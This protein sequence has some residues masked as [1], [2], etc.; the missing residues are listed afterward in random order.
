MNSDPLLTASVSPSPTLSP[1][2]LGLGTSIS[3]YYRL[4]EA[5]KPVVALVGAPLLHAALFEQI[6]LT[7]ANS[8]SPASSSSYPSASFTTLSTSNNSDAA[9]SSLNLRYLS[10]RQGQNLPKKKSN[11]RR[12]MNTALNNASPSPLPTPS[13]SS[14]YS[15]PSIPLSSSPPALVNPLVSQP[16]YL[17]SPQSFPSPSLTTAPTINPSSPVPSALS[18][19]TLATPSTSSSAANLDY[20]PEGIIKA[21]WIMK[22]KEQ[23]PSVVAFL[24]EWNIDPSAIKASIASGDEQRITSTLN[25]FR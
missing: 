7:A 4:L 17:S 1:P 3:H 10:W 21:E 11:P 14:S 8:N 9:V 5:P 12:N 20:Q 24:F 22:H 16:N 15:N 19:S 23:I 13:A 6:A 2:T 18:G 25:S